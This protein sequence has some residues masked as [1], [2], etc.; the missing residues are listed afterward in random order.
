MTF[1]GVIASGIDY[2][3]EFSPIGTDLTGDKVTVRFEFDPVPPGTTYMFSMAGAAV[4][5]GGR[6]LN[7]F[8]NDVP[9]DNEIDPPD[10]AHDEVAQDYALGYLVVSAR[11]LA[12]KPFMPSDAD[13]NS[14][15]SYRFQAGDGVIGSFN[16]GDASMPG[17]PDRGPKA[18]PGVVPPWGEQLNFTLDHFYL[19]VSPSAAPEPG[20]WALML[21]GFAGLGGA[22]RAGRRR[23]RAADFA[24]T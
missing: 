22:L 16:A 3:A 11:F 1:T 4:T 13:L 20:A 18:G 2:G 7:L 9:S 24:A 17:D 23:A 19:N 8:D 14:V 15:L 21:A 12:A 6:T 10:G 5:I